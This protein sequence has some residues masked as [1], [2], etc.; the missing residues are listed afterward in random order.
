VPIPARVAPSP[1]SST[2]RRGRGT[3]SSQ[4]QICTRCGGN[5]SGVVVACCSVA[6]PSQYDAV[7]LKL[8][9]PVDA[10]DVRF[11]ST[12]ES[13]PLRALGF[14]TTTAL[15]DGSSGSSGG[16]DAAA[17]FTLRSVLVTSL[18]NK[19]CAAK[20]TAPFS[21]EVFLC[22]N[23]RTG[24]GLCDGDGGGLLLRVTK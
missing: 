24:G 4:L 6:T 7:L 21:T 19:V 8:S 5:C 20:F 18:P 11:G 15:S 3:Y 17:S 10:V 14:G 9:E 2:I 1:R 16:G 22:A 13:K 23:T 12:T